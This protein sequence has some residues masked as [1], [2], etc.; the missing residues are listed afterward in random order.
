[1]SEVN[2]II[3]QGIGLSADDLPDCCYTQWYEDGMRPATAARRAI[4]N[5]GE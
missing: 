1:M 2:A 4:K 3:E 5:A